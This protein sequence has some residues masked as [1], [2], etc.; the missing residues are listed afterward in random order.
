[1]KRSVPVARLACMA[2]GSGLVTL[3]LVGCPGNLD[4]ALMGVMSG[5]G[6][7]GDQGMGGSSGGCETAILNT[8]C[9]M[10]SGCHGPGA[11]SAGLDLR[12]PVP[13]SR[14]VGVAPSSGT[15]GCDGM[16]FLEPGQSPARGLMITNLNPNPTCGYQMPF[17]GPTY[18]SQTDIACLQQWANGLVSGGSN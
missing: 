8:S 9:A 16:N 4:P 1:M 14:L 17:L 7:G 6:G 5:A 12:P 2:I 18:L 3:F 13:A 11:L 15:N 10:T